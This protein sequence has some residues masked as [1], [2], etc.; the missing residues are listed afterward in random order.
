VSGEAPE[1]DS[2]PATARDET[3]LDLARSLARSMSRRARQSAGQQADGSSGDKTRR[4][5]RRSTDAQVSGAHPDQRDPQ[6]LGTTIDRLVDERGWAT[7]VAVHGTF[8]R[9]DSIVG[10]EVAQHC[11]PESYSDNR[12]TVRADSTA[13]ATQMKLLAPT[14][15]RRLNDVLGEGTVL[16]VDVLGPHLPSWTKGGRT[17][18]DGR[19][20]RDTYG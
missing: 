6:P 9:W 11:H 4:R 8:G 14:V 3:G 7:D 2:D 19:G 1:R 10:P 20:P 5:R 16:H 13:W 18:R 17:L 12:L 15:V